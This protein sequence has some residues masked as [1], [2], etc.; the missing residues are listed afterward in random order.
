[1]AKGAGGVRIYVLVNTSRG[2][3]SRLVQQNFRFVLA[4]EPSNYGFVTTEGTNLSEYKY[5][6]GWG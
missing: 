4:Y 5:R 3:G 6:G 1:M 2:L